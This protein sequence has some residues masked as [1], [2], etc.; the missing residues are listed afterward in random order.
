MEESKILDPNLNPSNP[1]EIALFELQ[2]QF[3]YSVFPKTLVEGKAANI[4]CEYSDPQDKAK[5][6]DAQKIYADLCNFCKGG[7]MTHVS[8]AMLESC[9]TNVRLNKM[10]TKTV[11]TFVTTVLHVIRIT[12]RQHSKYTWMITPSRS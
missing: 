5:F 4:L 6:G 1:D 7:A 3:I 8:A 12:R 9:L 11:S 10:W 2:Q